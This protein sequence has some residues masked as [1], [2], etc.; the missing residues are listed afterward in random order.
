ML[1]DCRQGRE[2]KAEGPRSLKK[3]FGVYFSLFLFAKPVS[4]T[5]LTTRQ[6]QPYVT[7]LRSQKVCFKAHMNQNLCIW[8]YNL[9]P[10]SLMCPAKQ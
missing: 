3:H 5:A 6:I 8:A 2:A 7:C 1:L 9:L 4:T 10:F